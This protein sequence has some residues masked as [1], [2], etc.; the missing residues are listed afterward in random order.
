M[1]KDTV[2]GKFTEYKADSKDGLIG[3][4]VFIGYTPN[5]RFL[6]NA[7]QTDSSGYIITDDR[8]A[9]NLEGV[10]AAGD[11]RVKPLRQVVTAVSDGA[12][13]A[14]EAEKYVERMKE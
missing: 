1:F 11:I 12:V 8:M 3:V 2:S 5:T 4:F 7:V 13:A 6:G 14:V 10:F 9:T